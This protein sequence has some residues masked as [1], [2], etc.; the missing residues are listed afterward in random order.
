M[1]IFNGVFTAGGGGGASG[2]QIDDNNISLNATYSSQKITNL[3]ELSNDI[4]VREGINYIDL[5]AQQALQLAGQG[6]VFADGQPATYDKNNI[7]G[8]YY[9]QLST[10]AIPFLIN[11]ANWY[12]YPL[13]GETGQTMSQLDSVFFNLRLY[14]TTSLPWITVYT[15]PLG[16]GQDAQSWYR[17]RFNYSTNAG[18][19]QSNSDY[20]FYIKG[21]PNTSLIKSFELTQN[22][23]NGPLQDSEEILYITLQTNSAVNAG[24]VEFTVKNFGFSIDSQTTIYNLNSLSDSNQIRVNATPQ[25]YT[26]AN[27]TLAENIKGIDLELGTIKNDLLDNTTKSVAVVNQTNITVNHNLN[28]IPIVQ[29]I[30]DVSGL[31][32]VNVTHD[33]L[34][35]FTVNA[36]LSLTG[37]IIYY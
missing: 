1:G 7:N 22:A 4:V 13:A 20:V 31:S 29:Y 21:K 28:R 30:D 37:K 19:K 3:I 36:S 16:D 26:T 10:P 6:S 35:T 34:N 18:I 8:W 12:F 25:N 17:S 11:K 2:A 23:S 24:D 14:S 15:K 5:E 33:S 9:K 32:L 27:I